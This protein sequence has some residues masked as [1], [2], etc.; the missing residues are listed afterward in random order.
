[1]SHRTGNQS[2]RFSAS[3]KA[4]L[5]TEAI[6][7]RLRLHDLTPSLLG[8]H[9]IRKGAASYVTNVPGG[10]PIVSVCLRI[11]WTMGAVQVMRVVCSFEYMMYSFLS[12]DMLCIFL[13]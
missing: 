13:R 2:K 10:P 4:A 8:T 9:S 3:F 7:E 1:M 5:K 12:K 6:S 11:G